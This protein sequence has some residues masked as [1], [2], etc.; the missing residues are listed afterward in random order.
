M[1]AKNSSRVFWSVRGGGQGDEPLE[2]GQHGGKQHGTVHRPHPEALV[3]GHKAQEQEG[4]V[5]DGGKGGGAHRRKD[6]VEDDG[7]AGD[8]AGIEAVGEFEEIDARGHQKGTQGEQ[9]ILAYNPLDALHSKSLLSD[10]VSAV[11]RP[12]PIVPKKRR[13]GKG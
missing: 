9:G 11:P 8:A 3:Q 12:T 4:D 2:G 10:S 7:Q 6:G 5:D 13:K 1:T